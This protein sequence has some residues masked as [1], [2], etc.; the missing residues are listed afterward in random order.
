MEWSN[1]YLHHE[2][3]VKMRQLWP[4]SSNSVP[5]VMESCYT[6]HLCILTI[7]DYNA[8]TAC[9]DESKRILGPVHYHFWP[10]LNYNAGGGGGGVEEL[11]LKTGL[12]YHSIK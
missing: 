1:Y 9:S 12:I 7:D 5:Q 6:D 3:Q 10:E 4:L 11:T 8:G 2:L